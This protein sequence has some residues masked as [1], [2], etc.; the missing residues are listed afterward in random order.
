MYVTYLGNRAR[1]S[2]LPPTQLPVMYS[3]RS[4][5]S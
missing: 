1:P 4:L 2:N 3:G 5:A